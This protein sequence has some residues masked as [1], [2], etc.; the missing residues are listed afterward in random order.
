MLFRLL[1]VTRIEQRRAAAAAAQNTQYP[2]VSYDNVLPEVHKMVNTAY[3]D[4][5]DPTTVYVTQPVDQKQ[6]MKDGEKPYE[7][8]GLKP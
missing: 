7:P 4:P 1:E 3:V 5:N 2:T 8:T 6:A